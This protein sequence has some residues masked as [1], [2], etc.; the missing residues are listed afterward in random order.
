VEWLLGRV[1]AKDALRVTLQRR[2][3]LRLSPAD[4]EILPDPEGRPVASGAWTGEVPSVPILSLSHAGGVAVALVGD[5][6][7]AAGVGVD[8]ERAGRMAD[9]AERLAFTTGEQALLTSLGAGGEDVWPLRLWCAKEAVAKAL[10]LGLVGGPR[11]LVAEHLDAEKGTVRMRLT[12][13]MAARLPAVNGRTLVAHTS[14]DSDLVVA[15][16]LYEAE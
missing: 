9:D 7:A 10:G 16:S 11:A 5:A 3:G 8:V 12:G 1:L 2:Y 14:R 13:E 6:D 4:V 15:T